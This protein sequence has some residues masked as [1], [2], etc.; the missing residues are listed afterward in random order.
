MGGEV[1]G[2]LEVKTFDFGKSFRETPGKSM[3]QVLFSSRGPFG[4]RDVP[5]RRLLMGEELMAAVD[6]KRHVWRP[7]ARRNSRMR[8]EK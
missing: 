1:R 2:S 6:S 7:E 4:T 5:S 3:G 8:F